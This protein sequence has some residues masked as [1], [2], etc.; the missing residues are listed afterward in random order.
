M[1]RGRQPPRLVRRVRLEPLFDELCLSRSCHCLPWRVNLGLGSDWIHHDSF[2]ETT[3]APS[4][5][6]SY[7]HFVKFSISLPMSKADFTADKKNA[8]R[9][10][11]ANLHCA[12]LAYKYFLYDGHDRNS[13]M[14]LCGFL[15]PL[16]G[17]T[18]VAATADVA[19]QD[20]VIDKVVRGLEHHCSRAIL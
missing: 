12:V 3:A 10:A 13:M 20:V 5:L 18:A 9:F 2:E 1:P 14:S 4:A 15:S 16:L 6:T 11:R 8:F 19:V 17:R 7:S